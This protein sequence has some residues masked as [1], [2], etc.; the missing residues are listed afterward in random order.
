MKIQ[1]VRILTVAFLSLGIVACGGGEESDGK[2]TAKGILLAP[3]SSQSASAKVLHKEAMQAKGIQMKETCPN[4]PAGYKPLNNVDVEFIDGAGDT[5]EKTTTDECGNFSANV[6][7]EVTQVKA[8]S[9]GNKDLI[10]EVS[11]FQST[12][13][14]A[15]ASTIP[16]DAEYQISSIHMTADNKVA[17]SVTDTVTNNAVLGVP[18]SAVTATIND[19][20]VHVLDLSSASHVADPASI[21]LVMDASGSMGY[22]T[23][24]ILDE[25]GDRLVDSEGKEFSRFRMAALAAH[26]YLD[27]MPTTDETGLV[28]FNHNVTYINDASLKAS[29]ILTKENGDATEYKFSESGY[30]SNAKSLRFLIDA[31]NPFTEIYSDYFPNSHESL[32]KDSPI[33]KNGHYPWLGSTAV[34]DGILKGLEKTHERKN[35]RKF[36]IAMTDGENNSGEKDGNVVIQSAIDKA[37]PVYTIALG[38]NDAANNSMKKIAESTNASFFKVT[39]TDLVSAFQSI[40]TSITFQYLA[41]LDNS[42]NSGDTVKLTLNYN[43]ESA[44]RS[45][46]R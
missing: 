27:N 6:P 36:V 46:I 41:S 24:N 35:T 43:G 34:F 17:F 22:G 1:L 25:N 30:T 2:K 12:G 10:V 8:K 13:S 15:V 11:V 23:N 4:V 38:T 31:Y 21:T 45:V 40:Q 42:A 37:I 28:I 14:T 16:V 32:H 29:F 20:D 26:T 44:N 3:I 39:G 9:P 19:S 33:L 5:K 18:E 7:D